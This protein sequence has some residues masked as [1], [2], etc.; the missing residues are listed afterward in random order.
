[1]GTAE[2]GYS[3]RGRLMISGTMMGMPARRSRNSPSQPERPQPSVLKLPLS[4]AEAQLAARIAAGRELVDTEA[5]AL[6]AELTATPYGRF[7]YSPG[8]KPP[9]KQKVDAL[10]RRIRQWRDYNR[11]WLGT[12]LGGEA[13]EEYQ[14]TSTHYGF[15]GA[16]DPKVNLRFLRENVESEVSKLES[17]RERLPM[18]LP[19]TALNFRGLCPVMT[20]F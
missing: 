4:V 15:G 5:A 8:D 19:S 6:D 11:T 12:N 17:I 10:S 2:T 13:A 18:W 1:M 14:S 9:G 3:W 16:D 7:M 20:G